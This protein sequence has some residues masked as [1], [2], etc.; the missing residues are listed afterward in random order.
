MKVII[1]FL[2]MI[3]LLTTCKP[4]PESKPAIGTIAPLEAA[5]EIMNAGTCTLVTVTDN[6]MP[7][8]RVMDPL[9]PDENFEVWLATNPRSRKI[10]HLNANPNVVLHYIDQVD[11]GYVS[12]YGKAELVRD[13]I[14]IKEHWKPEWSQF[15]PNRNSDCV[16]IKIKPTRLEVINYMAGITGDPL[17]WQPTVITF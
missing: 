4:A 10:E 2:G 16:L 15:Y 7:Y 1:I 9:D 3:A 6:A 5:R 14:A 12:L 13:S 17:T 8:A 11:N